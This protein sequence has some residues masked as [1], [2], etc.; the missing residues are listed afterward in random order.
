[1]SGKELAAKPIGEVAAEV[2]NW[3]HSDADRGLDEMGIDDVAIPF[4]SVLQSGSPQC[5]RSDAKYIK[6]AEEGMIYNSLTQ[7]VVDGDKGIIVVPCA[8]QRVILEWK[9]RASGGGMA[10]RHKPSDPIVETADEKN[11]LP[12]GNNLEDTAEYYV[13]VSRGDGEWDRAVLAMSR[14]GL[15][16]AR[17][18]N[19]LMLG[20]KMVSP[21]GGKFTP[22]MFSH[23]YHLQSISQENAKGSWFGWGVTIDAPVDSRAIYEM[24]RAFGESVHK[25]EIKPQA[26]DTTADA[27]DIKTDDVPF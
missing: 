25:G 1:M 26:D 21:A 23:M 27:G 17:R 11:T 6:G 10:G 15:K 13:L 3:F 19:S 4:I 16:C 8:Y 24:A 2:L 7:T 9:P 22:P 18:W 5:K 14:T 20:I 12:S